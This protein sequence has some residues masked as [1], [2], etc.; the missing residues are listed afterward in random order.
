VSSLIALLPKPHTV[1][2][3]EILSLVTLLLEPI[4][5]VAGDELNVI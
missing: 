1:F 2:P 5:R 3:P 4:P